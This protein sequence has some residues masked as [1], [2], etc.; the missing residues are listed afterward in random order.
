MDPCLDLEAARS[1]CS[2][3]VALVC[4]VPPRGLIT[5]VSRPPWGRSL[6]RPIGLHA[7]M[8]GTT[9]RADCACEAPRT[10]SFFFVR[11]KERWGRKK[12]PTGTFPA[13]GGPL[14]ASRR[15]LCRC[16]LRPF[17]KGIKTFS[18]RVAGGTPASC[19]GSPFCFL[20]APPRLCVTTCCES[21][22]TNSPGAPLHKENQETRGDALPLPVSSA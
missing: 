4:G 11:E 9:P 14:P 2:I 18:A 6:L 19:R 10:P 5:S 12:K 21:R 20:P 22:A 13:G 17:I 1:L 8:R 3:G 7:G 16:G 15:A